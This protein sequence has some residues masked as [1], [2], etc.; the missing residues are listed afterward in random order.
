[1]KITDNAHIFGLDR[2]IVPASDYRESIPG[3]GCIT[4]ALP[5]IGTT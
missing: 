1:M 5:V 2:G 3:I 4:I